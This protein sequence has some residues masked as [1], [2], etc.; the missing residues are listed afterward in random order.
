M[1]GSEL[2]ALNREERPSTLSAG[3]LLWVPQ[4]G[5]LL[6]PPEAL[7]LCPAF[8]TAASFPGSSRELIQKYLL[9]E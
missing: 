1:L 2:M 8:L 9:S 3:T 4:W 5:E 7:P 6:M